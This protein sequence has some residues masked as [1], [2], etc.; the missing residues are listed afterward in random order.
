MTK[1]SK[2]LP[3]GQTSS[4]DVHGGDGVLIL[5]KV[6]EDKT[7]FANPFWRS[8]VAQGPRCRAE[9][10]R[11]MMYVQVPVTCSVMTVGRWCNEKNTRQPTGFILL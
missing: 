11:D 4:G 8:F 2:Y 3:G 6:L 10:A 5:Y 9:E 1:Q 7:A